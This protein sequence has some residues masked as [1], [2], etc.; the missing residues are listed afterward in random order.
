MAREKW[1]NNVA[2]LFTTVGVVVGLGNIWRFPYL[3]YKNGG[4]WSVRKNICSKI[5]LFIY[6]TKK[7]AKEHFA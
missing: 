6:P 5:C 7:Q 3:C 1:N 2:F 4:G